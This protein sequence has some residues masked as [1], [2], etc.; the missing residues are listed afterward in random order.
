MK[1]NDYTK[2]SKFLSLILRHKPETIEIQLD[3]NGWAVVEDLIIKINESGR[4]LN[5]NILDKIVADDS[6]KRYSFNDDHSKIR[7]NQGHSID[8]DLQLKEIEPP[9]ILYHGTATRF[10]KSIQQIGLISG[11]SR[12]YIHFSDNVHT[13]IDVG[14]RHGKPVV[15]V[16]DTKQMYS[17]GIKFYLSENN[18]WL[19]KDIIDY[20]YM[21][22]LEE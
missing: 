7:A 19:C 16:I 18:V 1:N 13:A 11:S 2:L 12:Q 10:L 20:K 22:V 5:I 8:I 17:N 6:K 3:S 15:L 4:N 9:D 14:K 21:N